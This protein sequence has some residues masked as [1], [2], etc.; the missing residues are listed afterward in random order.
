MPAWLP[1]LRRFVVCKGLR[2]GR[3]LRSMSILTGPCVQT[4][5]LAYIIEHQ[6]RV[7]SDHLHQKSMRKEGAGRQTRPIVG[8]RASSAGLPARTRAQRAAA[9]AAGRCC[10]R[11][12]QPHAVRAAGGPFHSAAERDRL[13]S[14]HGAHAL[15]R[16]V[17]K[18]PR[19]EHRKGEA[20]EAR[21][22]Q[23]QSAAR[24][25]AS[26]VAPASCTTASI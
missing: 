10:A 6:K 7:R 9:S 11:G 2:R 3:A 22:R 12:R 13:Q 15:G 24:S 25:S 1:I 4:A 26:A 16:Q 20:L 23:A 5:A 8:G 14:R 21:E 19:E 18:R 17:A